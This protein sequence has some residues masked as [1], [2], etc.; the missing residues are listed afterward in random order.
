MA[1]PDNDPVGRAFGVIE[2]LKSPGGATV[3][4][5]AE[6]LDGGSDRVDVAVSPDGFVDAGEYERGAVERAYEFGHTVGVASV[7]G[8]TGPYL[9]VERRTTHKHRSGQYRGMTSGYLRSEVG[10]FSVDGE[11]WTP[12]VAHPK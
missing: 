12:P 9:A 1:D 4:E 2:A 7:S 6:E 11:R 8:G 5:R 10:S 3:T